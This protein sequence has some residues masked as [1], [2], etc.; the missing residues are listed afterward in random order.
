MSNRTLMEACRAYEKGTGSGS[1]AAKRMFFMSFSGHHKKLPG[2]VNKPRAPKSPKPQHHPTSQ[3][4]KNFAQMNTILLKSHF[5]AL[6]TALSSQELITDKMK[7]RI[8]A[9]LESPAWDTHV[10]PKWT[11]AYARYLKTGDL[12]FLVSVM[13]V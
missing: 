8:S 2:W 12:S 11:Q 5:A 9:I 1:G 10:A 13:N 7:H 4:E 6:V 3:G